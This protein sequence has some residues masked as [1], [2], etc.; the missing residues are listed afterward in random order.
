MK[1]LIFDTETTGIPPKYVSTR[2]TFRFPYIVQ[3][4]WM[5]FDMGKNKI[6]TV[7]DHIIQLPQYLVISEE[8]ANIHGID[9]ATM[10]EKGENIIPILKKFRKDALKASL[11]VA[12]NIAFDKRIIEVEFHRHGL[13]E[14]SALRKKEY[15]TM[16]KG[17]PICNLKMKSYYSNKMI[18]KFPRLS[19]LHYKLFGE[20]PKNLHNALIDIILC[21][22]CYYHMEYECDVIETNKEFADLYK[23]LCKL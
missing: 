2:E 22:R 13:G 9:N 11:V 21:F 8:N 12:H 16:K 20:V 19:E 14:W 7:H 18:S 10:R 3:L 4:S 23:V 5:I 6:T 1:V 15:C 17:N